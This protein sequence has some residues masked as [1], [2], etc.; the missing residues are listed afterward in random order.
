MRPNSFDRVAP[1]YDKLSN[2]VFGRSMAMAQTLY[3]R[4][5]PK[6]A[7]VLILGGGTGLLLKELL[8]INSTCLVWYVDASSKMIELAKR[9]IP[10]SLNCIYFIHG[11][12]M[13]IPLDTTFDIVITHFYLDLFSTAS[14]NLAIEKIKTALHLKSKWLVT[15]FINSTWWQRMM[16]TVMYKFFRMTCGIEAS[17]LPEWQH[18][19]KKNGFVEVK[20]KLYFGKFIKSSLFVL[21]SK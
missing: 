12:E 3:L 17:Q 7:K 18:L 6:G 2:L 1:V 8:A 13:S 9:R 16:L 5:I 4:D 20:S 10:K 19:I 14:C 15:D 21:K 11:T